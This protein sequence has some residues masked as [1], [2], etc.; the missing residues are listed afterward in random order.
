ME[1]INWND[2]Y[3]KDAERPGLDS[4]II[5]VISTSLERHG[6]P[7]HSTASYSQIVE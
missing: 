1:R 4:I 6:R 5:D 3:N 7:L 2:K